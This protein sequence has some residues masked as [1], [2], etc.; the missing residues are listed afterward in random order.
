VPARARA[1]DQLLKPDPRALQQLP[2]RVLFLNHQRAETR[3]RV[4]S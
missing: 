2:L 3:I 1:S 4:F